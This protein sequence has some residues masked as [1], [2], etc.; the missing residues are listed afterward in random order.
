METGRRSMLMVAATPFFS[1]RGC[2]IRI[3]N[4]IKHLQKKGIEVTLCTYHHGKDLSDIHAERIRK[5]RW[6]TKVT[7]GA[8]WGKI[9]LDALLLAKTRTE[10]KKKKPDVLYAHLYEGLAIAWVAKRLTGSRAPL[11]F[12]CQGSLAQEMREY[13][14]KKHVAFKPLY[15]LFVAI[16]RVLLSL[17]DAIICS[18]NACAA[19]LGQ[20]YGISKKRLSVVQDGFDA[21]LFYPLDQGERGAQERRLLRAKL[22][23]GEDAIV[24][25]YAGSLVA[26]KGVRDFLDDVPRRISENGRLVFLIVGYGEL[27]NEYCLRYKSLIDQ[28]KVIFVGRVSYFGLREYL[29][30]ADR[31]IDPKESLTEGSA[32]LVHYRA[33][34]IPVYGPRMMPLPQRVLFSWD[35]LVEKIVRV[36]ESL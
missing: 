7:P 2:H 6:Y 18:S 28:G 11:V 26:A 32:K 29:V 34:G 1:D 21:D 10:M 30:I 24:E 16:E 17:P 15:Y 36:I 22:G 25:L 9:C 20:T 14:L 19:Y 31:A 13:H 8:S 12:D 23:I 27:E 5:V 35:A 33:C 4:E 3:Y